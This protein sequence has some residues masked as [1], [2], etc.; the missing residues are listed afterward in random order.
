[1]KC[2]VIKVGSQ[3]L[4]SKDSIDIAHI[5][6]LVHQLIEIEKCG[7]RVILVSSGALACG[8]FLLPSATFQDDVQRRQ[9]LSSIGQSYLISLYLSILQKKDY[10]AAQILIN[11]EDLRSYIHYE[12]LHHALSG[13][14]STPR[15]IPII[16]E[17]D[18]TSLTKHMFTD[19]DELAAMISTMIHAQH[20]VILTS[21]EGIYD[22]PPHEQGATLIKHI[23]L[24]DAHALTIRMDGKTNMGRGGMLSK[25]ASC[26]KAAAS[27]VITHVADAREPDVLTR[28]LCKEEPVGTTITGSCAF[29]KEKRWLCY[30][31]IPEQ[32]IVITKEAENAFLNDGMIGSIFPISVVKTFGSFQSAD[33]IALRSIADKLLGIG[34]AEYGSFELLSYLGTHT[35]K[36]IIHHNRLWQV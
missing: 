2:I 21:T 22:R 15:T 8:K 29:T 10:F 35:K 24:E 4:F 33:A 16:N 12:N 5:E 11:R 20:L 28:I 27:G 36:C 34:I 9:T 14:L 1:M 18:T 23:A 32:G 13:I 26:Q 17:N 3:T 7:M 25:F 30:S 19:N 6:R 31:P